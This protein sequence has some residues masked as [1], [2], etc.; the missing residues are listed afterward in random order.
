MLLRREGWAI[1]HKR[2]CRLYKQEQLALR[3]K[4]PRRRASSRPREGRPPVESANQVCTMDF[5]TVAFADGRMVRV[6]TVLDLFTRECLAIRAD[7]RF[8][9]GQVVQVVEELACLHGAP[10]SVR[11]DHGPEFSGRML[12]LWAYFNKV[13]LDFSR[14]GKPTD[15]AFIES[16]NGR[17]RQ[18]CLDPNWFLGLEEARAKIEAGRREYNAERPHSALGDLAPEEFAGSQARRTMPDRASKLA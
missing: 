5:L 7:G 3:R 2:V 10:A 8:T 13:T 17:F 14:P 11:V 16:F 18:E 12:D 9:G 4:N 15:N 1:N 6:L